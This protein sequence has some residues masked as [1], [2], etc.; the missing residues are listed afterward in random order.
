M[1]GLPSGAGAL[2][3]QRLG[4]YELLALLA[5]GGTAEIYLARIDGTSGFEKYVVVKCLH[6][7][8][9]DDPE[10]VSMFLDEARLGAVLDHSNIVQTLGLGEQDDRYYMVMEYIS[11]LSLALVGRRAHERVRGGRVP[12][13]I[14]LNIASQGCAGL[15][16]AHMRTDGGKPLNL[17]HRDISPQN[18]VVTFE[19]I[20]K[21]VDFGIAK[22]EHRETQTRSGTV[23]GKFAYMSPEQCQAGN[24]DARTDVFAMGVIMW[25]LLTGR[26]LF[27]REST[28]ETYQAVV[29]CAVPPPSSV[30]HE[31]DPAIDELVM[32]ALGKQ[33]EARYPSAEAM[34]EAMSTYLHHRGKPS[35][36]GEIA[37]FF[38]EGFQQEIEEHFVRMRELIE[39]RLKSVSGQKLLQWDSSELDGSA[40]VLEPDDLEEI[41]EDSIAAPRPSALAAVAAVGPVTPPMASRAATVP[42]RPHSKSQPPIVTPPTAAMR[43]LGAPVPAPRRPDP[44]P[45][46]AGPDGPATDD[47]FDPDGPL[48]D[49]EAWRHLSTADQTLD[50]PADDDGSESTR[51]EI[52][53]L[54]ALAAL[55]VRSGRRP[56]T[57]TDTRTD[58]APSRAMSRAETS[59]VAI[60]RVATPPGMRPATSPMAPP[61]KV[62]QVLTPPGL[63]AGGA[64]LDQLPHERAVMPVPT[65]PRVVAV[66]PGPV[67]KPFGPSAAVIPTVIAQPVAPAGGRFAEAPTVADLR[68][69]PAKPAGKPKFADAPTLLAEGARGSGFPSATADA[70]TALQNAHAPQDPGTGQTQMLQPLDL[71]ELTPSHQMQQFPLPEGF[72]PPAGMMPPHPI[73]HVPMVPSSSPMATH[74]PTAVVSL[75]SLGD[76]YPG[77]PLYGGGSVPS[78]PRNWPPWLLG[79][80]FVVVLALATGIT[81]AIARAVT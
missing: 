59:P 57:G 23:K 8:L 33:R 28:Y 60:P 52:N 61:R 7:H 26:R 9:A 46:P 70:P 80:M 20:V 62:G 15:H 53:P 55:D 43:P 45:V 12:V 63:R 50:R 56:T 38:E 67:G 41:I 39:G 72:A 6:D 24:V 51:I 29:E 21:V 40:S 71:M 54:E 68:M 31:L 36:P 22:A 81:V 48:T 16:Y 1:G 10:F 5:L 11:G 35:G 64:P 75:P 78:G 19:G 44:E 73:P 77:H 30:N 58:A 13:P 65:P 14:I 32:R 2:V 79:V 27:K 69:S 3:G 18:L 47:E 25:E 42:E 4:K 17:V 66:P 34:G 76:V 37:R 74:D 49:A